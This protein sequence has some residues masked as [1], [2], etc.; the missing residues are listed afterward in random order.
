MAKTNLHTSN[1]LLSEIKAQKLSP[2]YFLQGDEPYYIDLI[3]D[4]I[5]KNLL[6]D[7]Q[8]GFNQTILYGKD[9]DINT[10]ITAA[11]RFPMMSERQVIIVKEA[12]DVKDLEKTVKNKIAGKEIEINAL[13]EYIKNP[14]LSTTLVFCFKNKVLDGRKSVAKVIDEHAVLF[15]SKGLYENQLAEWILGIVKTKGCSISDKALRL[16]IEFVGNNLSRLNNEI[17]KI[18]TNF[19][20]KGAIEEGHVLKFVGVSKEYNVFELQNALS[21]KDILKCNKIVNYFAENAKEN[22]IQMTL[23]N[24][25]SYFTK[26]LLVKTSR[27]KDEFEASRLLGIQPFLAKEYLLAAKNFEDY[28]ILN[29]FGYLRDADLKSKGFNIGTM[30]DG[31]VMKDLVFKILH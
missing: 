10:I 1:S 7:A 26:I 25:Y 2:V 4:Y 20:G 30:N 24:M 8:K 19:N 6:S 16:L 29:I 12:Q 15:T 13:E 5:E 18:L 28:K 21:R 17:N 27:P 14:L 9:V 3:S 22:P 11:K 31:S 23:G